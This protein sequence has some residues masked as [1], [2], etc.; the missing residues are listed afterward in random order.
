[1]NFG[2][3]LMI[4]YEKHIRSFEINILYK[5]VMKIKKEHTKLIEFND[6][7]KTTLK[8][9]TPDRQPSRIL[10]KKQDLA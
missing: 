1:M 9:I 7:S 2:Y 8:T 4:R 6:Y 3:V 5:K 10:Q